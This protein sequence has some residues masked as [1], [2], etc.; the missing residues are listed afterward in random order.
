MKYRHYSPTAPVHVFA[1][2]NNNNQHVAMQLAIER[3]ARD[4]GKRKIGVVAVQSAALFVAPGDCALVVH[5]VEDARDLARRIFALLR[6]LDET[7]HVDAILVQ[8][9]DDKDEGLAVM[10]RLE[11][12]ATHIHH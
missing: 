1:T 6:A 10:N 7:D 12:A 3:L 9:V 8:G 5:C 2:N 11:K 4:E